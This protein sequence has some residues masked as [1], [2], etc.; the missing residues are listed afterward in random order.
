M[1]E[2]PLE[3]TPRCGSHWTPDG[4]DVFEVVATWPARQ[5]A[6]GRFAGG[7]VGRWVVLG[8]EYRR[9]LYTSLAEFYRH[10]AP[11]DDGQPVQRGLFSDEGA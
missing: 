9:A 5:D 6:R 4:R 1:T 7:V 8:V 10:L 2:L 3:T 11:L